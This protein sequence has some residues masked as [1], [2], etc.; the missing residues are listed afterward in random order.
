MALGNFCAFCYPKNE[1]R[2]SPRSMRVSFPRKRS[3]AMKSP[4][5]AVRVD[6]LS[7]SHFAVKSHLPWAQPTTM[8]SPLQIG[9][10]SS[11]SSRSSYFGSPTRSWSSRVRREHHFSRPSRRRA[12][13]TIVS[14]EGTTYNL[15][16]RSLRNPV[17]ELRAGEDKEGPCL[18][19]LHFAETH[20]NFRVHSLT[21][22]RSNRKSGG[23]QIGNVRARVGYPHPAAFSLRL[24]A[25]AT[26]R[27]LD[28]AWKVRAGRSTTPGSVEYDL[29]VETTNAS[30]VTLSRDQSGATLRWD[31]EPSSEDEEVF[32]VLCAVG[33][34]ARMDVKGKGS[35]DDWPSLSNRWTA[36][37]YNAVF[38]SSAAS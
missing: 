24:P 10:P 4:E 28:V 11:T 38:R 16:A 21:P 20:N 14:S 1:P 3:L 29:V 34:L 9:V 25:T 37:W 5:P 35:M 7:D 6:D 18:G 32:I 12:Q 17:L 15:A 13:I 33:V 36:A 30:L 2:E 19:F 27:P 22:V 26:Q 31:F 23:E 8:S